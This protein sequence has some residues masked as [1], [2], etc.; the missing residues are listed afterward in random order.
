MP[1]PKQLL[2]RLRFSLSFLFFFYCFG[3]RLYVLVNACSVVQKKRVVFWGQAVY[4]LVFLSI[5]V[6]PIVPSS[7][8]PM[9]I[10]VYYLFHSAF[11]SFIWRGSHIIPRPHSSVKAGDGWS[12]FTYRCHLSSRTNELCDQRPVTLWTCMPSP[13]GLQEGSQNTCLLYRCVCFCHCKRIGWRQVMKCFCFHWGLCHLSWWFE[14]DRFLVNIMMVLIR[15]L[16]SK[17]ISCEMKDVSI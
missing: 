11:H 15:D 12:I 2:T 1:V 3:W 7:H 16:H 4:I 10:V 5:P 13:R 8:K 14:T 17:G 9:Q 6:L